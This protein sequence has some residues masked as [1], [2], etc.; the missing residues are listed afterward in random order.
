MIRQGILTFSGPYS[1]NNVLHIAESPSHYI[2]ELMGAK[3]YKPSESISLACP[4]KPS[5][6][7]NTNSYFIPFSKQDDASATCRISANDNMLSGLRITTDYDF[8]L[9]K[10]K[11]NVYLPDNL[12]NKKE[13]DTPLL[14]TSSI[15]TLIL[16]DITLIKTDSLRLIYRYIPTAIII[17][18]LTASS[19]YREWLQTK[20][21]GSLSISIP[22]CQGLSPA[23]I[24]GINMRL[25]SEVEE[26]SRQLLSLSTQ[27]ILETR[28]DSFLQGN[29]WLFARC[30][31]YIDCIV[32]PTLKWVVRKEGDPRESAPDYLMKNPT[33]TYDILDLKTG[34]IK[35]LSLTKGKR[36][37]NGGF[38]RIRFND[39]VSE[40]ISQLKDYERY[41][42]YAE[43]RR[44]AL[45]NRK[46]L[47]EPEELKLIG[48]VGNYNNFD[49][50]RVS[51][52]LAAYDKKIT[53]LSYNDLVSLMRDTGANH[54]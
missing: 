35:Y 24:I 53:I 14:I 11:I 28:I 17:N 4:D 10:E 23:F 26:F 37:K 40:L 51:K 1:F 22:G 39:Y 36:T 8:D 29:K 50:I 31:G 19:D 43:N 45:E 13:A 48:V 5:R 21:N 2:C 6:I 46:I 41:F 52:A 47:I 32:K 49:D 9:V 15:K 34:A 18:K 27:Q 20:L 7:K 30:L 3:Q 16:N 38:V 44:W 42:S 33:G 54:G 25:D 12:I